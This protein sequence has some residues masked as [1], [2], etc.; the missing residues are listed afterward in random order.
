[1]QKKDC[2]ALSL[3]ILSL[4]EKTTK[5]RAGPMSSALAPRNCLTG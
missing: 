1:M 4:R 5:D 3:L 2:G